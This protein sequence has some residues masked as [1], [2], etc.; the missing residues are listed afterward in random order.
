MPTTAENDVHIYNRIVSMTAWKKAELAAKITVIG[1]KAMNV[2]E[3]I[4]G[5]LRFV[6]AFGRGWAHAQKVYEDQ[7]RLANVRFLAEMRKS[8]D[9]NVRDLAQH[10]HDSWTL[11]G[12]V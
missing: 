3:R 8:D 11:M 9:V 7:V 12:L 10:F 1:L 5:D 6:R 4:D 2:R